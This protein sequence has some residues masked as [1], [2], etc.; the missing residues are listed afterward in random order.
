MT[1]VDVSRACP[2][3]VH[4]LFSEGYLCFINPCLVILL[5]RFF[6]N[7]TLADI[8][9]VFRDGLFHSDEPHKLEFY[10]PKGLCIFCRISKKSI[11]K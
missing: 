4:Y 11:Y 2:E 5:C 1:A 7:I 6:I 8:R 10:P 9:G 3:V